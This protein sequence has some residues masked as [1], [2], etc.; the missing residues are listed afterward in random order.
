MEHELEH[1]FDRLWPICR[2]LTG[3]GN[4]ETLK[5]LSE[6][7]SGLDIIEV[8]A[9]TACLDWT[10]PP[11]WNI[12]KAW[13]RDSKGTKVVDFGQMLW[14]IKGRSPIFL[15]FFLGMPLEPP[16]AGMMTRALVWSGRV[17]GVHRR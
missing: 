13:I 14:P 5:I 11:E 8:P 1:Y 9:G 3:N 7:V 2:S 15:N 17:G 6:V 12:R 16:L 10:V 4:R